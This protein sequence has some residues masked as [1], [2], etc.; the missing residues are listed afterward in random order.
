ML[1]LNNKIPDARS[2]SLS[3]SLFT[4]VS[5]LL[6]HHLLISWPCVNGFLDSS[7]SLRSVN[8]VLLHSQILQTNLK[9]MNL[10]NFLYT[11]YN[12]CLITICL[13]YDFVFMAFLVAFCLDLFQLRSFSYALL[14]LLHFQIFQLKFQLMRPVNISN[15]SPAAVSYLIPTRLLA[16]QLFCPSFMSFQL[17]LSK[18]VSG[19]LVVLHS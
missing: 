9:L 18:Y 11:N 5:A 13:S 4:P 15:S 6:F 16:W 19:L 10:Y 1:V 2:L 8:Y 14:V 7:L 3:L 12:L 17:R